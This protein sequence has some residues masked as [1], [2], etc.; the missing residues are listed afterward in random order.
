MAGFT[1][2]IVEPLG[3]AIA[4][5]EDEI[6]AIIPFES[7]KF[8]VPALTY[9]CCQGRAVLPRLYVEGALGKRSPLNMIAAFPLPVGPATNG[10]HVTFSLLTAL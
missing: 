6:C 4:V 5:P 3:N 7:T 9:I 8:I 2:P 1:P 10:F